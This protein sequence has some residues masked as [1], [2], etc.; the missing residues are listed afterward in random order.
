M[1]RLEGFKGRRSSAPAIPLLCGFRRAPGPSAL[2]E[3]R[4]GAWAAATR[5]RPPGPLPQATG[6]LWGLREEAQ[7]VLRPLYSFL[8]ATTALIGAQG[9]SLRS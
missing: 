3:V 9:S 6:E 2:R 4:G 5:R 8:S 1:H 7:A